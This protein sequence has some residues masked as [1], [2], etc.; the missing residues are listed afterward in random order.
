MVLQYSSHYCFSQPMAAIE[1]NGPAFQYLVSWQPADKSK[2]IKTQTV[3]RPDAWHYVVED[4]DNDEIYKKYLVRVKAKNSKGESKAEAS[5][6][7]GYTG[8][9]G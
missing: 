2:P 3:G 8:E 6:V 5:W 9:G 7:V 1:Y 4:I